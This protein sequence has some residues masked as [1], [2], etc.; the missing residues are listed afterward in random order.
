MRQMK[1][2]R[3]EWWLGLSLPS[4]CMMAA[5]AWA[6]AAGTGCPTAIDIN[7]ADAARLRCLPGIGEKRAAA[8]VAFRTAHGPFPGPASLAAVIGPKMAQALR[9]RVVVTQVSR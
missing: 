1:A 9:A 2:A 3:K 7:L 4:L 6:Q 5:G 8:I